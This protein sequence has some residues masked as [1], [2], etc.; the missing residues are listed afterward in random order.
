MKI[1]SPNP[2]RPLSFLMTFI[3]P[4]SDF[5]LDLVFPESDVIN[6]VTIWPDN[7]VCRFQKWEHKQQ[8]RAS[9][10]S[11]KTTK[12]SDEQKFLGWFLFVFG[13]FPRK[14]IN[15][16]LSHNKTRV[17]MK[18]GTTLGHTRFTRTNFWERVER[19]RS[20]RPDG[21]LSNGAT[22]PVELES[23]L[24]FRLLALWWKCAQLPQ[25][26]SGWNM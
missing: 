26:V 23:L 16:T 6:S 7:W 19:E 20:T 12:W 11:K 4:L 15:G 18:G 1:D 9:E 2:M 21:R 17:E 22:E 24:T 8:N 13:N 10:S 3:A 25:P 14:E 5:G